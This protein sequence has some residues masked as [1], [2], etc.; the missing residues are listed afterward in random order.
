MRAPRSGVRT[1]ASTAFSAHRRTG[2]AAL[3][4]L[5]AA[6]ASL[7][8]GCRADRTTA[9]KPRIDESDIGVSLGFS[10]VLDEHSWNL[11]RLKV[12]NGG[13]DFNGTITVKGI[14]NDPNS[15]TGLGESSIVHRLQVEIPG[16]GSSPRELA[17]PVRPEGWTSVSV[18]LDQPGY[19]RVFDEFK[20][21]I[22]Q[23]TAL[24]ILAVPEG[25]MDLSRLENAI[26]ASLGEPGDV[27]A[28]KGLAFQVL[29]AADLPV[30]AA[31]HDPFQVVIL[32]GT[33]LI[34]APDGA[35]PA[36]ARWVEAGGTLVAL[37]GPGWS[38]GIPGD[39]LDLLGVAAGD[40]LKVPPDALSERLGAE[41]SLYTYRELRPG[42]GTEALQD[43]LA[44]RSRR[45]AGSVLA[46]TVGPQSATFPAPLEAPELHAA[47]HEAVARGASVAGNWGRVLR[48]FE[49]QVGSTLFRMTGFTA[50]S[51]GVV[52]L[53]LVLYVILGFVLPALIFGR[54]GRREWA[55]VVGLGASALSTTAIYRF[56][57]LSTKS[58]MEIEE[59]TVLRLQPGEELA[60]ATSFLGLMSPRIQGLS[61]APAAPEH[62][63][64]DAL[65]QPLRFG[66]PFSQSVSRLH[67]AG[68]DCQLEVLPGGR[69]GLGDI[70]LYPNAMQTFR[71]DYPLSTASLVGA[72]VEGT[73]AES[74][75]RLENRTGAPLR[76]FSIEDRTLREHTSVE[77]GAKALAWPSEKVLSEYVITA[78]DTRRHRW[79]WTSSSFDAVVTHLAVVM[80]PVELDGPP[81]VGNPTSLSPDVEIFDTE[82]HLKCVHRPR[83][84]LVITRTPVF[85]A[86][87]EAV[88]RNAYT[89]LVFELP[90]A[91]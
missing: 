60:A 68:L 47:L 8:S 62:P 20:L 88:S 58:Q 40:P 43:G 54:R 9:N 3:L 85:P 65:P 32:L 44:F 78:D 72:S 37:A 52:F 6:G 50:P 61:L 15:P 59:V 73:G 7:G 77:P 5:L 25:N 49:G 81:G 45:G 10:R 75:L 79:E 63:L 56:G 87:L 13:A 82:T 16:R 89:V 55:F 19:S 57:L 29:G 12:R 26:E 80:T 51:Q 42:P 24:R 36:L 84:V 2:G 1:S 35:V 28:E 69:L 91:E 53:S 18:R 33:A 86:P 31:A 71:F 67:T 34:D 76:I 17:F 30:I 38:A 74:R 21:P 22:L 4:C 70:T 66:D 11:L 90:P 83:Q 41:V 48:T 64:R 39:L 46:F 23:K 27:I 14:V